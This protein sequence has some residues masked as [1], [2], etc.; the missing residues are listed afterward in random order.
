MLAVGFV[1]GSR[2]C[3]GPSTDMTGPWVC[4][5][6]I[7]NRKSRWPRTCLKNLKSI[8]SACRCS[9]SAAM[10]SRSPIPPLDDLERCRERAAYDRGDASASRHSWPLADDR[11]STY[12]LVADLVRDAAASRRNRSFPLS[13]RSSF[14]SFLQCAGPNSLYASC[15]GAY[16]HQF[17]DRGFPLFDYHHDGFREARNAFLPPFRAAGRAEVMLPFMVV[18]ELFSFLVRPFSL[19]IRLFA[20]M[21]AGHFLLDRFRQP[22]SRPSG[23]ALAG[24]FEH[25]AS[26]RSTLLSPASSFSLRSCRLISTRSS[27]PCICG[28]RWKCI[29]NEP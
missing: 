18:I 2:M 13:S 4:I 1:A 11:R 14:S 26:W 23:G 28:M 7:R 6:R 8:I 5:R 21:L 12:N 25:I 3:G 17:R 29:K 15:Y 9:P 19:S 10:K 27:R 20:N 24:G 22:H 16:H